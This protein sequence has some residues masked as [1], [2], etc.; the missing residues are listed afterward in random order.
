MADET[1]NIYIKNEILLIVMKLVFV[2]EWLMFDDENVSMV[3]SEDILKL[4]GGGQSF[5]LFAC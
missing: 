5:C 1:N 3:T 4:S 2:D